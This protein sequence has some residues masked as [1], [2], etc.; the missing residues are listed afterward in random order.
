MTLEEQIAGYFEVSSKCTQTVVLPPP[1]TCPQI[2]HTFYAIGQWHLLTG[3][4]VILFLAM[5]AHLTY[6]VINPGKGH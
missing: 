1:E 2:V 6:L 4:I 5:L 3:L